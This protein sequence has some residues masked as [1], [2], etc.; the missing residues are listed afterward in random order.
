MGEG[1]GWGRGVKRVRIAILS[2]SSV[3]DHSS[4]SSIEGNCSYLSLIVYKV[5]IEKFPGKL[6]TSRTLSK[7]L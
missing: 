2:I 7:V 5:R 1:R 3:G 4:Q 6:T